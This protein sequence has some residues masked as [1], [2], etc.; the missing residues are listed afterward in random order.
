ML[1]VATQFRGILSGKVDLIGHPVKPEFDRFVGG[2]RTVEIVDQGDGY[3]LRHWL[4]L[5]F[6]PV[7]YG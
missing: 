6:L 1:Q 7:Q 3:F 5:A 2:A 4:T